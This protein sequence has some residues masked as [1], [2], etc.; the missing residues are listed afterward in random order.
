MVGA[1]PPTRRLK[2]RRPGCLR[3]SVILL[4]CTSICVL[5]ED[6]PLPIVADSCL[7]VD[8]G[9]KFDDLPGDWSANDIPS[10]TVCF[11]ANGIPYLRWYSYPPDW[12]DIADLYGM[13][14]EFFVGEK[15]LCITP[16]P[17]SFRRF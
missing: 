4:G 6:P 9:F 11:C 5:A 7:Q 12:D 16:P 1:S 3:G 10:T 13:G 14:N 8:D 15:I 2:E 17:V